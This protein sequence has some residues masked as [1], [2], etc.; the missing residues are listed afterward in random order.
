MAPYLL[1][2]LICLHHVTSETPNIILIMADDLGYAD[3]TP[4]NPS[5][6][7]T[8][9]ITRLASVGMRFTDY[10]SA[11]PVCTPS[12][13]G[14]LTGRLAQRTG[15][16]HNFG[17]SSIGGLPEEEKTIAHFLKM[18]GY[19][20]GIVGKWHL[21]ITEKYH[22]LSHGFDTYFGLP[23]SNDMGCVT[24]GPVYNAKISP[25]CGE[26]TAWRNSLPLYAN[27]EIVQQPAKLNQLTNNYLAFSKG[28]IREHVYGKQPFFLYA[29]L[30]QPHVPLATDPR[31]QNASGV[32]HFQDTLMEIDH[33]VGEILDT[34][35]GLGV[36]EETLVIFTSD[37]G[38]W[39][40]KCD[41]SGS[42]FPFTGEYQRTAFGG[43][44]TGKM[45]TWEGGHRVPFIASWPGQ[46]ESG[47]VSN[48]LSSAMDI[49]CD[50][51]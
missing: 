36:S 35:Y 31:F 46:I 22:P 42:H 10:H 43:G 2:F 34:V 21:G 51:K 26:P 48:G 4:N 30:A 50:F 33:F 47:T 1:I 25:V 27:R 13:A 19:A 23:F 8:P 41:L 7:F 24:D 11:S 45:T 39:E 44:S 9:N 38:P 14:L 20:T 6:P 49:L 12:R 5:N 29:P 32:G 28:F 16:I 18:E 15:M 37:N 3:I 40:Y 17:P